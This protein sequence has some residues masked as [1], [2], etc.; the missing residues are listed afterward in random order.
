VERRGIEPRF[1][2]LLARQIGHACTTPQIVV[3]NGVEPL[4]PPY[5]SGVLA[6]LL[7][8]NFVGSIGVEPIPFIL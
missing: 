3:G 4:F 6:L 2:D 8:D 1:S 7:T 5:Q